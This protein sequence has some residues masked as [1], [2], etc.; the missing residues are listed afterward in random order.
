MLLA[1]ELNNNDT[2]EVQDNNGKRIV[3]Q[4]RKRLP[5]GGHLSA[6]YVELVALRMPMRLAG[7]IARCSH[8]SI[9]GQL[10]CCVARRAKRGPKAGDCAGII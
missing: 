2:F 8:R 6:A 4:Q 10:L 7:D 5:I 3:V 1:W 9:S